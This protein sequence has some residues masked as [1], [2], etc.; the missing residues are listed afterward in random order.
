MNQFRGVYNDR[1]K[2]QAAGL[3]GI[4]VEAELVL[5][6][7]LPRLEEVVELQSVVLQLVVAVGG[8]HLKVTVSLGASSFTF[9][10]E[11]QKKREKQV[12]ARD[13]TLHVY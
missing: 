4:K 7:H 11:N 12:H 5:L 9:W 3:R 10:N 2:V 6:T 8:W 13:F 1:V